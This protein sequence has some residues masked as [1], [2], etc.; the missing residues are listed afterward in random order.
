MN[1]SAGGRP[2]DAALAMEETVAVRD[3]LLVLLLAGPRY[4]FQLHGELAERTGGRRR[5]NVG[6]TYATLERLTVQGLVEPAGTTEDGRPLH[7]A[8]ASGRMAAAAW[9]AGEDAP[10]GDPWDETLDRVLLVGS[11]GPVAGVDPGAVIRSERARWQDRRRSAE[12][13]AVASPTGDAGTGR[14][15]IPDGSVGAERLAAGR[16]AATAAAAEAERCRA[17]LTWLDEVE[18]AAPLAWES[19]AERPARG[20]RPREAAERATVQSSASA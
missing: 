1:L 6:Q 14:V 10:A 9:L 13:A 11:L 15:A 20:R 7:A 19:S 3:A 5:I 8:T 4:G 18:A 16:L 17:V 2:Q 12:H